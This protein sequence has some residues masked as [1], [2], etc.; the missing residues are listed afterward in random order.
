MAITVNPAN[1]VNG[2]GAKFGQQPN[3]VLL[4]AVDIASGDVVPVRMDVTTGSLLV[5]LAVGGITSV[6]VTPFRPTALNTAQVTADTTVGGKLLAAAASTR[7]T[8]LLSNTSSANTVWLGQSGVDK[9][10]G[11]PLLPGQEI[12][13]GAELGAALAWYGICDTGLTAVVGVVAPT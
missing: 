9:T 4:C 1:N 8:L 11:F 6:T 12:T 5:D 7:Q 2:T 10:H 3:P 13:I